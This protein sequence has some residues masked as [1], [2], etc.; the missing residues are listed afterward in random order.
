MTNILSF[1]V[2][3]ISFYNLSSSHNNTL[4]PGCYSYHFTDEKISVQKIEVSKSTQSIL[5]LPLKQ[6]ILVDESSG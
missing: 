1:G 4:S 3:N 6:R 2:Y 5:N